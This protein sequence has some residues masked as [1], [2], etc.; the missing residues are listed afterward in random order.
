M[1]K[2]LTAVLVA[3][4]LSGCAAVDAYLMAKY[5]PVEY[6]Y[7]V[8]IKTL[9]DMSVS[10]CNDFAASKKNADEIYFLNKSLVN[11]STHIPREQNVQKM[12]EELLNITQGMSDRYKSNTTVSQVYCEMKFKSVS[13]SVESMLIVTGKKPR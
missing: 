1:R 5:D 2:L 12:A 8:K 6:D 4:G 9:S 13:S 7:M 3:S 11:F 10:T